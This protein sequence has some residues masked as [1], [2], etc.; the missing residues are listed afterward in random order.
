MPEVPPRRAVDLRLCF[1]PP[2]EGTDLAPSVRQ[3]RERYVAV[4]SSVSQA[5]PGEYVVTAVRCC[6][7]P[8]RRPCPGAVAGTVSPQDGGIYW[9]CGACGDGGLI[10]AWQETPADLTRAEIT[11]RSAKLA[12]ASLEARL[13]P[14]E[15]KLVEDL[16]GFSLSPGIQDL[17]ARAERM[18]DA[19][20]L[21]GSYADLADL[22]SFL[23]QEAN[24]FMEI[25]EG[26]AGRPLVHPAPG[27]TADL[28]HRA[29]HAVNGAIAW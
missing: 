11:P 17:V 10:V 19:A 23:A 6:R 8:G 2:S 4:A 25:E 14:A 18:M 21:R 13:G 22:R 7:R 16:A 26:P 5:P 24:G 1:T 9:E 20:V 12:A 3:L 15:F 29:F 27:G 28:L